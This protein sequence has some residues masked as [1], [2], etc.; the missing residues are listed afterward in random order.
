VRVSRIDQDPA[1]PIDTL[2]RLVH[3][4]PMYSENNHVALGRL[5]LGPRDGARTE[6]SDKISQRLRT[7]GIRYN[8]GVT[9]VY[10]VTAECACYVPGAQ[11]TYFHNPPPTD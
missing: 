1:T 11:K 10:Q 5:L 8:Y 2:Q 7:S 3:V 6:I 9:S 4:H